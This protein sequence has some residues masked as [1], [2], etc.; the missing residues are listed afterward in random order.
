MSKAIGVGAGLALV[1]AAVLA[2]PFWV[3][4]AITRRLPEVLPLEPR[5]LPWEELLEFAPEVGWKPRPGLDAYGRGDGPFRITTDQEGW[6]GE[7]PLDEADTVVFGD[8]F[9]FGHGVDDDDVYANHMSSTAVKALGSDGYSMVHAVLWMERLSA[10]LRSKQLV[11]MIYLGND[12]Y[13]NL[14]PNYGP[15]RMPYVRTRDERWEIATEHVTTEPWTITPDYAS[16]VDELAVLCTASW[17]SDRMLE[18]AGYLLTRAAEGARKVGAD[19]SVVTVPR[20]E[21]ID[22]HRLENLRA[23]SP[24]P[25]QF[26]PSLP[27]T[28]LRAAAQDLDVPFL[29]LADHLS[30]SD[31]QERDIHWTPDGNRKVAALLDGLL[32][33]GL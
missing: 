18:A 17:A 7:L 14:R 26:D 12:L 13:D 27:D 33:G 16:Y 29:A 28:R 8:S 9:A 23:R 31:Y 20:R 15:Y 4:S 19:L 6:R 32:S 21:Q 1:P 11:W 25:E 2:T 10:R 30:P 24:R 3:V 22:P 5:T